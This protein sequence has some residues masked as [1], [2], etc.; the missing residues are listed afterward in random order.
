M[1]LT[2]KLG[3]PERIGQV[4]QEPRNDRA[5]AGSSRMCEG[6]RTSDIGTKNQGP[7][8]SKVAASADEV[9]IGS[10]PQRSGLDVA[11]TIR[12]SSTES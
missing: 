6:G 2:A 3:Q 4:G 8:R 5:R 12:F 11:Y 7:D 10:S 1:N 9:D